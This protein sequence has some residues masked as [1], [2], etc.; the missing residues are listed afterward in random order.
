MGGR[1]LIWEWVIY[2]ID[3]KNSPESLNKKY[4]ISLTNTRGSIGMLRIQSISLLIL[5]IIGLIPGVEIHSSYHN[6]ISTL[7]YGMFKFYVVYAILLKLALFLVPQ[8]KIY[9][10]QILTSILLFFT[11]LAELVI[12]VALSFMISNGK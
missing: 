1:V 5:S 2:M 11:L 4:F 3:N 9:K 12:L 8:K 6:I 7:L 10:H